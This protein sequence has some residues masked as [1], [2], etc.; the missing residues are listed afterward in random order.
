MH[1]ELDKKYTHVLE[2]GI[3]FLLLRVYI[4]Y[5]FTCVHV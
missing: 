1:V 2:T 5:S 3:R 4:Y